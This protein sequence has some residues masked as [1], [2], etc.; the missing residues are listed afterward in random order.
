M[1]VS[2][3]DALFLKKMLFQVTELDFS[4]VFVLVTNV[5]TP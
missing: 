5:K 3:K 2:E 1:Y 4:I